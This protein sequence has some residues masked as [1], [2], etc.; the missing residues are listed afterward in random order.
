ME[1][2]KDNN[3]RKPQ[4]RSKIIRKITPY[5]SDVFGF[6]KKK[7]NYTSG[8]WWNHRRKDEVNGEK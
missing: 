4:L 6:Y 5:I 1:R 8:L 3:K 7:L 2:Q